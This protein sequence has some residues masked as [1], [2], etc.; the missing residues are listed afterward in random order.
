MD[1]S[2]FGFILYNDFEGMSFFLPQDIIE[3]YYLCKCNA[4]K[5]FEV[6]Y[7]NDLKFISKYSTKNCFP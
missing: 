7:R 2:F 1:H 6:I 5:F 3:T 4:I